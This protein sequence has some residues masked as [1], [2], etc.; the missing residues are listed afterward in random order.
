MPKAILFDLGDTVLKEKSYNIEHGFNAIS[1]YL[2]SS[3]TF[4]RLNEA[5]KKFQVSNSEF[6][7]LQ[8]I[9]V[10]LCKDYFLSDAREVELE[11]WKKTVSLVPIQGI[12]LVLDFLVQQNIRIAAVSNAAFS[13]PC[14]TY[15]LE[16]HG[17]NNY[18][19]FI[20]SSADLGVRKPDPRIF[21]SALETLDLEP[22]EVWYIGD[23]WDAD[24][25]GANSVRM[26]P[27]WFKETFPVHDNSINHIKLRQWSDFEVVWGQHS[28]K[29]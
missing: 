29:A 18:F 25:I 3:V 1:K 6:K 12:Q 26:T 19:E 10:N 11:L 27:V 9:S 24:I 13:S 23:R 4:E 5:T 20:L 28:S 16:K 7:L 21:Q 2:S 14:M 22:Q 15:E 17:L 8:W